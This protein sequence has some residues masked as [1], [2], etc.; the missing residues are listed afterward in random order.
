M[1][2]TPT[3]NGYWLVA[4]DGG[5]FTFGD[6]KFMGSTGDIRL[7][8]PVIGLAATGSGNGYWL[9][10][11]DGGLFTFGDAGYLGS[12][13]GHW[14]S[15]VVGVHA[16][17]SN[18]YVM[19]DKN[20]RLAEFNSTRPNLAFGAFTARSESREAAIASELYAKLTAERDAR[21]L[22]S[23]LWDAR[24][25]IGSESWSGEMSNIGFRHSNVQRVFNSLGNYDSLGENI[26][27]G[28]ADFADSGSAHNA[29]MNSDEHRDTLLASQFTTVG[30]GVVCDPSGQLWVTVRFG[31][32]AGHAPSG[33]RPVTS[34][35]PVVASD[36]SDSSC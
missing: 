3:D 35:E 14:T 5:I 20:A 13:G 9:V 16:T 36:R 25:A 34:A 32:P 17:G 4:S 7:N 26:Y 28:S 19:V 24:I 22:P 33:T 6:A 11:S 29:F 18:G 12:L 21:G 2:P 31:T 15:E 1:A 10:A 27:R 30:I 23:L 8:Q